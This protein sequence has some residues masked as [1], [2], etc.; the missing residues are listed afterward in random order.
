MNLPDLLR[1]LGVSYA[2]SGHHHCRSGWVQVKNC[3]YCGSQNYHLGFSESGKFFSCWRCRWHHTI[4]TLLKL[5][6]SLEQAKAVHGD[7]HFKVA[8]ENQ[9]A[10]KLV[11]PEG[12]GEMQAPHR[13]YLRGRKFDPDEISVLWGVKGFG[14]EAEAR[15]RWRLYIPIFHRGVQVSWTT[16]AIGD[17]EQ[18]YRSASKEQETRNHKE[19]VYGLDHVQNSIVVVEG[20][21]DAWAVGPG[22]GALFGT[23]FTPEQVELLAAIPNRTV[24]FDNAVPAQRAAQELC[25]QLACFPGV[26]R[27]IVLEAKDPGG[28]DKGEIEELRTLAGLVGSN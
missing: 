19:L 4:P 8:E 24:C 1:K 7:R 16:R 25:H 14:L 12:V 3:P 2:T 21:T 26:T 22:A 15:F 6:A 18:R 17:V 20:P 10:T 11:E 5:G 28:A 27:N 9:R 23:A 13:K